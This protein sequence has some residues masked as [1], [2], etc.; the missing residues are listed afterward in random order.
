MHLSQPRRLPQPPA[1]EPRLPAELPPC[2][3]RV[4]RLR[5][6]CRLRSGPGAARLP[7]R[8]PLNL[9]RSPRC[10]TSAT[11][12]K[13]RGKSSWLSWIVRRKKR[14]RSSQCSKSCTNNLKCIRSKSRRWERNRSSSKSRRVMPR[15]VASATRQNL[16]MDAAIIVPIAKPSS[17]LDVEVECLYAQTRLCGCVIC[18]ENNKKSSL[19][20]EHGFII[21][22]L[23]HCSNLIKRFL[24][25]FE[26]RKP[27]RRRKQNYTS[28]PSSKEP[29]VT[30]QYL[31]L[32]KAELMGSQDRILLK[33]DQE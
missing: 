3:P 7:P 6:T 5:Q 21:V 26:M 32:R 30:Y 2:F 15:P 33:M 11:S 13:R 17:V 19:N 27:L 1:P 28:S 20:Q 22:G 10:R 29:Q 8:R 31:Q 16:Q 12:R 18:A 24:E 4:V 25:G 14:R 9:L 23:T